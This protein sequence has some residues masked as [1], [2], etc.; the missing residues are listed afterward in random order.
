MPFASSIDETVQLK[1]VSSL[2]SEVTEHLQK[3][4]LTLAAMML[5]AMFGSMFYIFTLFTPYISFIG[6]IITMVA[7]QFSTPKIQILNPLDL[8]QYTNFDLKRFSLLMLFGFFQGGALGG[9]I[10][11]ALTVDPMI[12]LLA[13]GCTLTIFTCF[14]LSALFAKRRTYL[15]LGGFLSSCISTLFWLLIFSFFVKTELI[16]LVSLYG[17]L[18]VFCGYVLYDTQAIIEKTNQGDRDYIKH[19][20]EL[21][22]DFVA[23]F[24]RVLIIILK[25]RKK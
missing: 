14:T 2:A 23:I 21:F 4:Y 11:E 7:L 15:Y 16:F 25:S 9:L 13:F 12:V 19:S 8:N 10:K 17:G 1:N 22:I 20:M 3:V 24:V 5:A 6:L 18:F